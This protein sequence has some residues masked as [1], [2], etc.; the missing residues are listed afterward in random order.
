MDLCKA[1]FGPKNK[2]LVGLLRGL[3]S[4]SL[5]STLCQPAL[6]Y[7]T[8]HTQ[9][10]LKA[11]P[12]GRAAVEALEEALKLAESR[13]VILVIIILFVIVLYTPYRY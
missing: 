10:H 7:V 13:F 4:V 1:G 11:D 5:S 8:Y 3:A 6:Y 9:A 2:Q 12:D